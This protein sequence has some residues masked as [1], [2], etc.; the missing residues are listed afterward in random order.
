MEIV[1]GRMRSDLINRAKG[2]DG[3][4]FSALVAPRLDGLIRLAS[5][6][7][8]NESDARDAV[9]ETLSIAWRE[10]RSLRRDDRFDPWVSRILI[11]ECR[12]VIRM[13]KRLQRR[14]SAIPEDAAFATSPLVED[15]VAGR[16]LIVR[17]L[18]R[19]DP[20]KRALLALR[21]LNQ[22]S[23]EEIG[24]ILGIPPGTVKSRLH[25]ARQHLK[26]AVAEEERDGS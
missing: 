16:D 12:R 2:G 5:A 4:A 17:A 20:D 8:G 11:N 25:A 14:E 15:R 21:Y 26:K 9:Q 3:T 13:Q 10:L 19:I 18:D 7:V 23:I 1:I 6:I 24:V 22:A